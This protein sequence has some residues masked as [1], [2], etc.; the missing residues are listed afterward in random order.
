MAS[1]TAVVP[2]YNKGP[3]VERAISS[4]L[5]QA[6]QDFRVIVVDDGST[7]DG[8]ERVRRFTDPRIELVTQANAGPGAARNRGLGMCESAYVGFLDADDEYL[9]DFLEVTV[10]FLQSHPDAAVVFT[11]HY[12]YP[13][14]ESSEA[15]FRS[16]GL[17]EGMHR[18]GPDSMPIEVYGLHGF[19]SPCATLARPDVLRQYGGFLEER[20]TYGEDQQLFLSVVMNHPIGVLVKP[21]VIFHLEASALAHNRPTPRPVYPFLLDPEPI[22]ANC[23]A[24]KHDLLG[25]YLELRASA[26][27]RWYLQDADPPDPATARMLLAKYPYVGGHLKH[28]LV[29]L[30]WLK[31]PGISRWVRRLKRGLSATVRKAAKSC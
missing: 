31:L 21:H 16:F 15:N 22:F 12:G 11:G 18:V 3:Y 19:M 20:C 5:A 25:R 28:R 6:Y 29:T 17:F 9:P 30:L 13:R 14:K 26:V 1:V 8:P 2:V 24:E 7:D 10:A 23:P 4:I 27:A